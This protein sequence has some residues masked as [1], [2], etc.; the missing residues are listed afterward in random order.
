MNQ[1]IEPHLKNFTRKIRLFILV[2]KLN[3]ILYLTG[4][5]NSGV[6]HFVITPHS[7]AFTSSGGVLLTAD[8][9]S[10]GNQNDTAVKDKVSINCN[11]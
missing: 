10:K 8:R 4:E 1:D 3:C 6:L 7:I 11:C 2:S 5:G 9:T